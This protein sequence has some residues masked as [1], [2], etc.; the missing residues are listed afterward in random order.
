MSKFSIKSVLGAYMGLF[1]IVFEHFNILSVFILPTPT[2]GIEVLSF[3]L[4]RQET[5]GGKKTR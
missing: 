1:I 5:E 4:H 2:Q 3:T